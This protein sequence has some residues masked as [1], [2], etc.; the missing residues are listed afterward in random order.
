MIVVAVLCSVILLAAAVMIGSK[1]FSTIVGN[2]KAE[3]QISIYG[4]NA[5]AAARTE[6]PAIV[7]TRNIA[8]DQEITKSDL[9]EQQV[10]LS[11]LPLGAMTR[12]STVIGNKANKAINKGDVVKEQDLIFVR[13]GFGLR[14]EQPA[15]APK[16]K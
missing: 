4:K 2:A 7:A 6:G 3:E 9:S 1:V 11:T 12:M 15:V 14:K 10:Q 16:H 13:D 5:G 8:K